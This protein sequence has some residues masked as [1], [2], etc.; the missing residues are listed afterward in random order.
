MPRTIL[1][2]NQGCSELRL[3]FR[4]LLSKLLYP[5]GP[6][7]WTLVKRCL[8]SDLHV[9]AFRF[10]QH[11]RYHIFSR[12]SLSVSLRNDN[13]S[14]AL[15][16]PKNASYFPPHTGCIPPLVSVLSVRGT[17]LK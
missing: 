5:Y 7:V 13:L 11:T 12:V 8:T 2:R 9:D 10:V 1:L 14:I 17:S 16:E 6:E 4:T 15:L 3:K